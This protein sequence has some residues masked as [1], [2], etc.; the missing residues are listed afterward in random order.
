MTHASH[1]TALRDLSLADL[2]SLL[3]T[4]FSGDLQSAQEG[5]Q[6]LFREVIEPLGDSFLAPDRQLQE[7]LLARTV[8]RARRHPQAAELDARLTLSGCEDES[9]LQRRVAGLHRFRPF[10]AARTPRLKKVLVLSRIT[11]GA[12]VL[13]TS[14]ILEKMRRVFP[15]AEIV[16]VGDRK[17]AS[18]FGGSSHPITVRVLQYPRGGVLMVRLLSWLPLLAVLAEEVTSLETGEDFIVINP[19]SR[20]LQSG[21]LPVFGGEDEERHYYFWEGSVPLEA[22]GK[23]SQVE[24]LVEWLDLTFG[25]SQGQRVG[26]PTLHLPPEDEAFGLQLFENLGLGDRAFVVGMNLGV[27]G[28][29]DKR[30]HEAG[31]TL[32]RFESD[33]VLQMLADGATLILDK[34]AGPGEAT[35]A[36]ELAQVVATEGFRVLEIQGSKRASEPVGLDRSC[37]LISFQGSAARFASLIKRCHL[38]LGYDSLGQHLAGALGRDVLAIFAAHSTELFAQRWH[39]AGTGNIRT[40]QSGP[41]PFSPSQQ[42]ILASEV[43]QAYCSMKASRLASGSG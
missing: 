13:L 33:L 9:A 30:I 38:Y 14:T 24:D 20:L 29:Q 8:S 23:T 27:G 10:D 7:Q 35:R 2:D 3:D 1:R 25:P 26:G 19:D 28:N 5:T 42:Q 39:T 21:V 15:E 31:E 37:Q 40:I 17:N 11:L 12:D 16:F 32:S 43:L 18:L 4:A 6:I 36:H 34:G 22:P 41:G